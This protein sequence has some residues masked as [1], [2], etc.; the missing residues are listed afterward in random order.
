MSPIQLTT[1]FIFIFGLLIGS[2]L[3]CL[4]WRLHT[5]ETMMG[6]SYCPKCRA[7]LAWFENIPLFSWLFLRG[8]CRHCGKSI[9]WQ[10]PAVELATALLFVLAFRHNISLDSFSAL[11]FARDIFL[12][13]VMIIIF[14]FDLRWYL[15]LDKI[16]LPASVIVLALNIY[17]GGDW[18]YLLISGIIGAGFFYTQFVLSRGRAVGGGDIRLGLLMGF[19]LGWPGIIEALVIAYLI[20]APVGIALVLLGKKGMKSEVP[21]GTF[22]TVATLIVLFYGEALLKWYMGI[23]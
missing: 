16:S 9:L 10:Y 23:L 6:R 17:L 8:H 14:V 11:Q 19:A 7:Q 12:I 15:I 3:N 2:F 5:G 21:M 22:L 1:F 20:G 18:K 4:I 13:C